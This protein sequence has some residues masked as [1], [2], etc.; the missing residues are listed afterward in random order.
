MDHP[1]S[2]LKVTW[3]PFTPGYFDN[4]YEHLRLCRLSQPV[5]KGIHREWMLFRHAHIRQIL[6]SN[7]FDA[8]NLS[9]YFSSKEKLILGTTGCPFLARGT[10]RWPMYLN[11]IEHALTV[12]LADNLLRQVPF[13]GLILEAV[14][15]EV[16][17]YASRRSFDLAELATAIP[18][19]VAKKMAGFEDP[20]FDRLRTFSHRL[21]VSQ[22]LYL[23]KQDY[24]D[25][26]SE[27]EWAFAEFKRLISL[28]GSRTKNSLVALMP[29]LNQS[30]TSP[31][32][33]D[34]IYSLL[35]ILFMASFETTKDALGTMLLELLREPQLMELVLASDEKEIKL[36]TEELLRIAA[37]L[38]YTV[39]ICK[40]DTQIEDYFFPAGTRLFLALASANRDEEVFPEPDRIMPHRRENPHLSFG[41]GVHTCL[42]ARIARQEIRTWLKPLCKLLI[43]YRISD[44]ET[45]VW[46]RTIF[47]RG[48]KQL[49][50]HR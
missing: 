4:P 50:V 12:E 18:Y 42:G 34:E 2:K 33:E 8:S 38:Q 1:E 17:R 45:P 41:G 14:D 9:R 29:D 31:L 48:L 24:R 7:G 30:V 16:P 32:S 28:N 23:T 39:R 11:G 35:C 21:A 26:N 3:N 25:V 47:M 44:G 37:P 20:G 43:N 6:K 40:H 27:F 19:Y 10:Q 22:D 46:Q 36:V 5:Q 15:F 49:I 13:T